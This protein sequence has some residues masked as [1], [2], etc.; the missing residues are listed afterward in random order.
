[1]N[2]LD[3][4]VAHKKKEIAQQKELI[5]VRMLEQSIYY[6]GNPVS[7][8]EYLKRDDKVGIIAEFKKASPS[9]AK[10]SE[11]RGE[12]KPF[13][14]AAKICLGY[15]QSGASALSVL[16][17][18]TFFNGCNKDLT[19]AREWNFCPILRKDFIV[20]EYQIIEAKSIGAD[21]ILLIL[22]T[23]TEEQTKNYIRL[24]QD[25][26]MEVLCEIHHLDE[27]NNAAIETDLI[28]INARSLK[29][30]K[31]L[32]D[33]HEQIISTLDTTKPLIAASGI[34]SAQEIIHRKKMGYEGFLIGSSFM[35]NPNPV[36]ACRR[37]VDQVSAMN[38]A[39]SINV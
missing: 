26:G 10:D 17:D 30:M 35:K 14:D 29:K 1:M 31:T 12:I 39:Q 24:A 32:P 11:L 6:S 20:D 4:I 38:Q 33:H 13:A 28:G 18:K 15:M 22:S 3:K 21:V 37:L 25:L 34:S 8:V 7:L 36:F 5:P 23:L 9:E 19:T 16:T 27:L 2:I